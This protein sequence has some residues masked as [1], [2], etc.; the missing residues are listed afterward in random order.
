MLL[1]KR[2]RSDRWKA[3]PPK[4]ASYQDFSKGAIATMLKDNLMC[5]NRPSAKENGIDCEWLFKT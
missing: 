1:T 2:G 5:Q 3:K 4:P